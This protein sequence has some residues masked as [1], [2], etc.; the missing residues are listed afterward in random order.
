[1]C[2]RDSAYTANLVDEK[3][4]KLITSPAAFVSLKWQEQRDILL[5]LVSEVTD[6]DVIAANPERCV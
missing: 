3:V 4:F 2:I 5:K 1:M 6:A